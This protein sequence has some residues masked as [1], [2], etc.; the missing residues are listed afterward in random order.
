MVGRWRGQSR[1]EG[2]RGKVAG[3]RLALHR[4]LSDP[5]PSPREAPMAVMRSGHLQVSTWGATERKVRDTEQGSFASVPLT[6]GQSPPAPPPVFTSP[7]WTSPRYPDSYP[8]F[9][10]PDT[11]TWMSKGHLTFN[12]PKPSS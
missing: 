11:P 7:A 6:A 8:D 3:R 12:H 2:S 5:C 1:M 9:C 10:Q 4:R